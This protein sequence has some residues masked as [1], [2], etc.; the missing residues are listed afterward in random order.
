VKFEA[1][2]QTLKESGCKVV[3]LRDLARYLPPAKK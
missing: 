3:A 1:Y 2:M